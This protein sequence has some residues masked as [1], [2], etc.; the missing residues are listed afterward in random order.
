MDSILQKKVLA[1][2]VTLLFLFSTLFQTVMPV[3]AE[4]TQTDIT[5]KMTIDSITSSNAEIK[6]STNVNDFSTSV[7]YGADVDYKIDVTVNKGTPILS[8]D[9]IEIPVT[10]DKG[11][12]Y[13]SHGLSVLDSEDG[14]LLGEATITK[15]KIRIKFTKENNAKT[16]AKIT[17]STTMHGVACF[18]Q[19]FNTQAEVDAAY[20]ANPTGIDKIKIYDKN[21]N[22]NVKSNFWLT[23]T[24]KFY[25]SYP[26]PGIGD[27][28]SFFSN[29]HSKS[30]A[31]SSTNISTSWNIAWNSST[32]RYKLTSPLTGKENDTTSD[33]STTAAFL[34]GYD[35]AFGSYSVTETAYMEDTLPGDIYRNITLTNLSTRGVHLYKDGKTPVLRQNYSDGKP[36]TCYNPTQ[37]GVLKFDDFFTKKEA[38]SG[39][40]YEQFKAS[41]KP[42]EYGIYKNPN[43]DMRLVASL[44]K[45]GS[46]DPN[47]MYTWGALCD[48]LG[49]ERVV[50]L[51]F[52]TY[53]ITADNDLKQ[54]TSPELIDKVYDQIKNWPI[55]GCR[56]DFKADLVK[57]VMRTGAYVE[58]TATFTDKTA[59]AKNL[60]VVGDISLFTYK[61]GAAILKT[62]AKTGQGIEKAEF[63]LQEKD[64]AGNWIDTDSQY[65]KDHITIVGSNG[66]SKN[67]DRLYTNENGILNIRGLISGKTYRLVETKAPDGYDN[68]NPAISKEFVI[69][70]TDPNAA[71]DNKDFTLTNKKSEY[72]VTYKVVKN[73][74]GEEIPAGSPAA[75]VD[76]KAYN[77]KSTVDVKPDLKMTG[78]I[79]AGWHTESGQKVS[80]KDDDNSFEMPKGD[81]ELVGY[82]IKNTTDISGEKTWDDGNNQDGKRP[83]K[84]TVNLMADGN[85]VKTT[86]VKEDANGKWLYSFKGV[87]K[88]DNTGKEIEYKVSE[89]PVAEYAAE[90]TG[91]NI[92][93]SYTPHK[94]SVTV[95][96]K[97][98]D[99]NNQDGKRPNSIKVQLY[100]DDLKI[101]VEIELTNATWSYTW[102]NLPEKKA[103]KTIK[104]T[105]KEVGSVSGYT[106]Y[107]D[108]QNSQNITI[109]N[110]HVPEEIKVEGQKTWEDKNNQDGKRPKE[111]MV[112][113]LANGEEKQKIKVTAYNNWK[114]SFTGLPKYANGQEITYTVT[115]DDVDG[116]TFSKDGF[117]IKN[118]YTPEER[119]VTVTKSWNDADNQDGKRPD[120]VKV[121]LYANGQKKGSE[122]EL[123]TTNR[124]THTWT[125]LPKK[126][127][128]KDIKYTVKETTNIAGYTATVDDSDIGNIKIVN[129]HEP[130][131]ISVKGT[132]TWDDANDQDGKR[133]KEITVNLL[134]NGAP[135]KTVTVK[136]NPIGEW[137]YEFTNLDK[138]ESGKLIKYTVT[139]NAVKDYNFSNDGYNIKNSYTPKETSVTVTKRWNDSNDK[140][141]IRPESIKVQLYANG[142]KKGAAVELKAGNRWSYTWN[143]LPE[144][145]KGKDIKYTVKEVGKLKG[146]T[147]SLDDKDH[148]NIII[149]NTHTPS[150]IARPKTGDNNRFITYV[151][152][153]LVSVTAF[154]G[155]M[156]SRKRIK[157]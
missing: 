29:G 83:G 34:F 30:G 5:G 41:L 136:P 14:S 93:N 68:S 95:T 91:F 47:K 44:G 6:D 3:S 146:Y 66:G 140:D 128:G 118:S 22:V 39:Q 115:E 101:G 99:A 58:N 2:I 139:E 110:K 54:V 104:Y 125:K 74:N 144:K 48:K 151:S 25:G 26:S 36:T 40:S 94:T 32:Y 37:T 119:G 103:G 121:Q 113:L 72:K 108:N 124:W 76:S 89:N 8:G 117:N 100:G 31:T 86:E 135:F 49:K 19:G 4:E 156:F 96:K 90:I 70:F 78:Y 59:T 46:K 55:T 27:P 18:S 50:K 57:P 9:Y 28:T 67:G 88:Y 132:K 65:V 56:F 64:P 105:V 120:S 53:E 45:I 131:K 75:P 73:P 87:P 11:Q 150:D 147:V 106:T 16:A 152:L 134:K 123:N 111:I 52:P 43:G 149:T 81:V 61:D 80:V 51:F 15:D 17:I 84:I 98:D 114:Y 138:Y 154:V 21:V 69:D 116:Y 122:I 92:K 97:W 107:Y 157:N 63:K 142:E 10:A 148:G 130:E 85:T 38:A 127:D 137:K 77:Y 71:S 133:P 79:F 42:G 129:T 155:L 62:D 82:W 112:N 23:Q 35:K 60:F 145:E 20:A 24:A 126:A 153:L 109:T 141:K 102:N 33:S 7:K 143:N 12:L 13:E 1:I